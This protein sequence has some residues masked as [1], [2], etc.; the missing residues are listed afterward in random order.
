MVQLRCS[1]GDRKGILRYLF[2]TMPHNESSLRLTACDVATRA[3]TSSSERSKGSFWETCKWN[4]LR[5]WAVT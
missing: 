1:Y 3:L 2:A 5:G 4:S